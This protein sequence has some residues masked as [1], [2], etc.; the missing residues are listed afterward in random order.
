MAKQTKKPETKT[1]D[2]K[3][4]MAPEL[5]GFGM[6]EVEGGWACYRVG[7]KGTVELLT[8]ARHGKH[9]ESKPRAFARLRK[10]VDDAYFR[11]RIPKKVA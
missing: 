6:D 1:D 7:D 9:A 11:V 5:F 10:A 4:E 8:P 3:T 2:V